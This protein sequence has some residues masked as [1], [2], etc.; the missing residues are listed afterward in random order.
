MN[1]K[2]VEKLPIVN[3]LKLLKD[4]VLSRLEVQNHKIDHLIQNDTPLLEGMM[5]ATK[6]LT[7]LVTEVESSSGEIHKLSV[8]VQQLKELSK[9]MARVCQDVA[10][11]RGEFNLVNKVGQ[12]IEEISQEIGTVNETRQPGEDF[13]QEVQ[14][15]QGTGQQ[16][17]KISQEIDTLHQQIAELRKAY[18]NLQPRFVSLE[19]SDPETE[20]MIFLYPFLPSTKAID[21][22]ANIGDVSNALRK[23]G[24]EVYAFEPFPETYRSL[25]ER[26]KDDPQFHAFSVALGAVDETK[27]LYIA[28]DNSEDKIYRDPSLYNSLTRHAMPEDMEFIDSITVEVRSLSSLHQAGELPSDIGLAKIDTEGFDLQVIKGMNDLSYS[29][30]TAEFWDEKFPF[31]LSGAFNR[32]EDIVLNMRG[33]GYYW[34]I[35]FYRVWGSQAVSFYC[36]SSKSVKNSWG[37]IFFFKN[38]NIFLKAHEWCS[39]SIKPTYIT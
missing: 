28:Q 33:K 10:I 3:R 20:L 22:G 21:V 19:D 1:S 17:E 37:N 25:K 39:S 13:C 8:T 15:I 5:E 16:V 34:N 35:V 14:E 2:I 4:T 18:Q 23:T 26:F 30:V 6:T 24:Y 38:Y 31:G 7:K 32:L 29:V 27:P 12:K 9:D 11:I 36:N